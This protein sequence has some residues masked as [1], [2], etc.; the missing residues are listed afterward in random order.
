[1]FLEL[2]NCG[3]SNSGHV[4]LAINVGTLSDLDDDHSCLAPLTR[5]RPTVLELERYFEFSATVGPAEGSFYHDFQVHSCH[6]GC[7]VDV[8]TDPTCPPGQNC[9]LK[10][11]D[12]IVFQF[13]SSMTINLY[14]LAAK[15]HLSI[16]YSFSRNTRQSS[17][18]ELDCN[19]ALWE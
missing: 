14:L 6:G 4:L 16:V 10:H 5:L 18:F 1:M 13:A 12:E 17:V 7:F 3:F 2:T 9:L 15:G 11:K 8:K 19:E